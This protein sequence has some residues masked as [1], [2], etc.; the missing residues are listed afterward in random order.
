[1]EDGTCVARRQRISLYSYPL[2]VRKSFA[3]VFPPLSRA[4]SAAS[5][6][7]RH[8]ACPTT[9]EN[10]RELRRPAR[11]C[12]PELVPVFPALATEVETSRLGPIIAE[13][14]PREDE[15]LG[16]ARP[17]DAHSNPVVTA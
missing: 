8:G 1:M 2:Q 14:V 10:P 5:E 16:W 7:L 4:R 6:N 13:L 12:E 17:A 9:P 3:L 11:Q 15:S